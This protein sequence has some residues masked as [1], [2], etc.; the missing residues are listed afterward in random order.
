[1]TVANK[2][3]SYPRVA[4]IQIDVHPAGKIRSTRHM[5][6]TLD[7]HMVPDH[8]SPM[9]HI[10]YLSLVPTRLK[11]APTPVRSLDNR[12]QDGPI[13]AL[14]HLILPPSQHPWSRGVRFRPSGYTTTL[15][16]WAHITSM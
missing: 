12:R 14:G 16:Y 9:V 13:V 4:V 2:R 7:S 1:M 5:L 11:H 3:Y 8:T 6:S 10:G 15:A